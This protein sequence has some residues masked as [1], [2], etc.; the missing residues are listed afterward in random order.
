MVLVM[1]MLGVLVLMTVGIVAD[2]VVLCW[3][4]WQVLIKV[5]LVSVLVLWGCWWMGDSW[6]GGSSSFGVVLGWW[7]W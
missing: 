5:G 7:Q 3:V 1:L 4:W 2:L 6:T